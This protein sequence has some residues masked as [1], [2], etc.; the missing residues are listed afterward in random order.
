[1]VQS[2]DRAWLFSWNSSVTGVH[3]EFAAIAEND[4]E[5]MENQ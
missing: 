1:M 4:D 5:S 3:R 2:P